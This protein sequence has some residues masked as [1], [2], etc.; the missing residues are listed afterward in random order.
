MEERYDLFIAHTRNGSTAAVQLYND[1]RDQMVVFLDSHTQQLGWS[2]D[3]S[4]PECLRRSKIIVLLITDDW[5]ES[6]YFREEVIRAI[7]LERNAPGNHQVL[8][9]VLDNLPTDRLP[10]GTGV[11]QHLFAK[12]PLYFSRLKNE[13][14]Q[15]LKKE[16]VEVESYQVRQH[17]LHKYPTGPMVPSLNVP[18]ELVRA[19]AEAFTVSE[20]RYIIDEADVLRLEADPGPETTIVK[21]SELLPAE[22][23]T[24]FNYWSMAFN[25]ACLHGPRMLAALLMAGPKDEMLSEDV[26]QK[27][28]RL[29]SSLET[30]R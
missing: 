1:F 8:T 25:T 7:A 30:W 24:P 9:V 26:R 28:T 27:R 12:D 16:F 14:L 15:R 21:H 23:S 11:K 19:Y 17:F 20:F 4:I 3:I 6:P 29:L 5:A 13:I 10:Y 22:Y 2:W 18:R